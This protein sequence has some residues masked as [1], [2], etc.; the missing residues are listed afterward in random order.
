MWCLLQL[1]EDHDEYPHGFACAESTHKILDQ[2]N[3]TISCKPCLECP[4]GQQPVP[5]CGSTVQSETSTECRECPPDTYKE[6]LGT[7]KCKPCQTCGLR[8]TISQCTPEK[9]TLCGECRRGYY[10]EDYKLDSCKRC[11]TCCGVKRFAELKCIYLKQCVRK[12]CTQQL[13][14]KESSV[15]IKSEDVMGVAQLFATESTAHERAVTQRS[16]SQ[17]DN[18]APTRDWVLVDVEPQL[19]KSK[20][21]REVNVKMQSAVFGKSASQR[22]KEERTYILVPV[23][24]G[25]KA[26]VIPL[27]SSQSDNPAH[28]RNWELKDIVTQ[29]EVNVMVKSVVEKAST[30]TLKGNHSNP[31]T[32]DSVEGNG[33]A[34][35][36]T[37]Q[38]KL[39][40]S[41]GTTSD[42]SVGEPT[43]PS[44]SGNDNKLLVAILIVLVAVFLGI[45]ILI[46]L[47]M[48]SRMQSGHLLGSG[49]TITCCPKYISVDG[50][51]F[52]PFIRDTSLTGEAANES[53]NNHKQENNLDSSL[54]FWVL[55]V[56]ISLQVILLP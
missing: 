52:R 16:A 4:L 24:T 17:S 38:S 9:N 43:L 8:Q 48:L 46:A 36:P 6:S 20:F 15:L 35:M 45:A 27:R 44:T 11:S 28:A 12:N 23:S 30:Y 13:K 18:P 53:T 49:C 39:Q 19:K 55:L 3:V 54:F 10:Q 31:A 14:I 42:A 21:K 56:T 37:L 51:E 1:P 41:F 47:L 25:H 34:S 29:R 7:G 33:V 32:Q 22:V 50:D 26:A 2:R 40:E 5:P